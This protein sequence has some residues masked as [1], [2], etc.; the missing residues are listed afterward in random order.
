MKKSRKWTQTL[1]L[2]LGAVLLFAVPGCGKKEVTGRDLA[3]ET[4]VATAVTEITNLYTAEKGEEVSSKDITATLDHAYLS[5]YT[6]VDGDEK[7]GITFFQMT[8]HNGSDQKLIANSLSPSFGVVVD[9]EAYSGISVR[10]TRFISLQFGE[11]A[12]MF[13]DPIEPGETRQ[14]YVYL[15]VP[16]DFKELTL[17]YYPAAGLVDWTD[18][19]TYE[20]K[21]EDMEPTPDP[22]TPFE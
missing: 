6:F 15:E 8:I 18:G 13:N 19:Y 3:D 2:V 10:G 22:V 20:M 7:I 11:N 12:E 5:P 17:Y 1:S 4:D 16:A 21:R 9:G 14:G